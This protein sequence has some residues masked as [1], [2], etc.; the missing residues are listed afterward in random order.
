MATT[1]EDRHGIVQRAIG[2]ALLDVDVYEEVEADVT[3]TGQ[4][5]TVV[6]VV[7][8]AS[9]L[10][11]YASGTGAIIGGV[12]GAFL[13]WGIFAGMTMLIGTRVFG[14]TADWGELLRTLGFAQV[15]GVLA[16]LTVIPVIGGLVAIVVGIWSIVA[17]VV[18]IRQAL[19]FD[20]TRAILTAISAVIVIIVVSVVIGI[21]TGVSMGVIG[22]I[23]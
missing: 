6:L 22:T 14:G 15:P 18:A 20:T 23:T 13:N 7:A 12:V 11:S 2:A 17:A 1:M 21:L 10:A 4:A 3:A 19:D 16:I 8:L 9:A 5:A